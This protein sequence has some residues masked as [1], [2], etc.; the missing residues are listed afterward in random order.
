MEIKLIIIV[1]SAW[2]KKEKLIQNPTQTNRRSKL[3]IYTKKE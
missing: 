1:L 2:K 3:Y